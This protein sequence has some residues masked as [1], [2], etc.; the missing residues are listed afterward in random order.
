M[1][2]DVLRGYRVVSQKELASILGLSTGTL[3]KLKEAEGFPKRRYFGAGTRGWLLKDVLEW[4]DSR[5]P[6]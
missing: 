3:I 4:A 6:G 2:D 5:P 1:N